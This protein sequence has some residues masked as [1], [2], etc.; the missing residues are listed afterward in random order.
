MLAEDFKEGLIA[1]G[2]LSGIVGRGGRRGGVRSFVGPGGADVADLREDQWL[3]GIGALEVLK[4]G[5]SIETILAVGPGSDELGDGWIGLV[6]EWN[7]AIHADDVEVAPEGNGAE[8]VAGPGGVGGIGELAGVDGFDRGDDG[9]PVGLIGG[10]TEGLEFAA[11]DE[12]GKVLRLGDGGVVNDEGLIAGEPGRDIG[13]RKGAL[14]LPSYESTWGL[15]MGVIPAA[16]R[17]A[18]AAS[19]AAS[20][21]VELPGAM[22]VEV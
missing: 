7:I 4:G 2:L 22:V 9:L 12:D 11:D 13:G 1:V 5:D 20:V 3:G 19:T 17:L 18:M 15:R 14:R 6:G 21:G 10:A 16:L 8:F